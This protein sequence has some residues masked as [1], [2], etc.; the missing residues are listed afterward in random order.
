MVIEINKN[1]V[2]IISNKIKF[3]VDCEYLLALR[4][5]KESLRNVLDNMD[6][7]KEKIIKQKS[8]NNIKMDFKYQK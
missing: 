8:N 7:I 6:R 5:F 2:K 1:H 4:D 3:L